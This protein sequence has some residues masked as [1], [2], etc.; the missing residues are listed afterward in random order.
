MN[1]TAKGIALGM[2]ILYILSPVDLCP[3]IIDDCLLLLS[4]MPVIWDHEFW[5]F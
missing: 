4:Q 3:G 1:D 2:M 5:Q